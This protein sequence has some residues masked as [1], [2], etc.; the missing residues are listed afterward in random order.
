[1][2]PTRV[3]ILEDLNGMAESTRCLFENQNVSVDMFN[4]AD[5]V[6]AISKMSAD[7]TVIIHLES[8]NSQSFS[9]LNDLIFHGDGPHIILTTDSD[10]MLGPNDCFPGNRVRILTQP[11][12]PRTLIDAVTLSRPQ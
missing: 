12:N 8:N 5:D 7:D 11:V 10:D 3:Y 6:K 9:I 2:E 1:M 4:K